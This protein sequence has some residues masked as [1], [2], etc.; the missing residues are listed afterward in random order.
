M[1]AWLADSV[2]APLAESVRAG[3]A[4][5]AATVLAAASL[6]RHLGDLP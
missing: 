5:L 6:L 3:A 2:L 4:G 1:K